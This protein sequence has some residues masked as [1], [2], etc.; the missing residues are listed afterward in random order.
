M[1]TSVMLPF[2]GDKLRILVAVVVRSM[3]SNKVEPVSV[4]QGKR[5]PVRNKA[6]ATRIERRFGSV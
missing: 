6:A 3:P 5:E 2:F 1:C 4:C